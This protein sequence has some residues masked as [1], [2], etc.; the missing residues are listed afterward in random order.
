MAIASRT[1]AGALSLHGGAREHP[2]TPAPFTMVADE[3][4]AAEVSNSL[5]SRVQIGRGAGVCK[6]E[7][8]TVLK[9]A[10]TSL[11]PAY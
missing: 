2:P 11:V 10:G 1:E 5:A 6:Y 9:Y 4:W 3:V 7:P 8:D